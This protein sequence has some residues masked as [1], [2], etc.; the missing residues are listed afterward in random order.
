MHFKL[1]VNDNNK[2][3]VILSQ[4]DMLIN[5]FCNQCKIRAE[6]NGQLNTHCVCVCHN[7]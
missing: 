1:I 7:D 6:S 2:S 4:F 3:Y 5:Y